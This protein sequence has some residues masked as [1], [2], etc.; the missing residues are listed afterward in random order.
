MTI[1]KEVDGLQ[2][3]TLQNEASRILIRY[4]RSH[5]YIQSRNSIL[6]LPKPPSMETKSPK[7]KE[8]HP[9]ISISWHLIIIVAVTGREI[10][11][12]SL[13]MKETDGAT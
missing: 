13:K 9:S 12:I 5:Q 11:R 7:S 8:V 2:L 1:G 6:F 4:N 3:S 10:Q